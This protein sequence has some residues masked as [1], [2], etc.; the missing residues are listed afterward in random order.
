MVRK[1]GST[2]RLDERLEVLGVGKASPI[3]D[4]SSKEGRA[5]N[6]RVRFLIIDEMGRP[7]YPDDQGK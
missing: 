7:V 6:R 1:T 2:H 4:N 3:D 5:K